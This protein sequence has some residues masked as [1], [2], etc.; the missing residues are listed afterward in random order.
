MVEGEE[1]EEIVEEIVEE[2]NVGEIGP[3]VEEDDN[4]R[5]DEGGAIEE[6]DA[7][8]EYVVVDNEEYDGE[9]DVEEE[10]RAADETDD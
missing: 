3:A 7:G 4:G 9:T 5:I 2:D 1:R 6:E 8:A 10:D